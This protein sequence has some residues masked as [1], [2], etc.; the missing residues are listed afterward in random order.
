MKIID[1]HAHLDHLDSLDEALKR[2]VDAGVEGIVAVSM[3]L[4]SC[5][6]NLEIKRKIKEPNIYLALGMHPS[7]A[8]LDELEA[9]VK[10][11]QENKEEL[12]AIGEIGLDFW[13]KWV[14][15]DEEKKQEQRV[16]FK[17]FLEL[18][19][20][21]DLPVVIHSRGAWEES[22]KMT[23][24]L[25][26]ERAEF[27]WYSGPLDVLDNILTDGYYI[28]GTPSIAHSPQSQE[29]V[30]HACIEQTL[31]ET[32]TPVY[33]RG[34]KKGEGFQ[35]EPKDVFRTLQAYCR[36]KNLEEQEALTVLNQN[37]CTFFRLG[38]Q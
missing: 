35:S 38:D 26:V 24:E 15:K 7:E 20:E 28:S 11:V 10:L 37:A 27:H 12:I 30:K 14:N 13:Y 9:C 25:G 2:A 33:Y 21:L 6:K 18:G 4:N 34:K 3:D 16:V 5:R 1:T 8:N 31:I 29:A 22:R 32:D 19:K 36:L 17:T 23:R